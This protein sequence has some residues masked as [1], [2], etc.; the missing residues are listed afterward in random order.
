MSNYVTGALLFEFENASSLELRKVLEWIKSDWT[1]DL[2]IDISNLTNEEFNIPIEIYD[3]LN[4]KD[5][6]TFILDIGFVEMKSNRINIIRDD[7]LN[8]LAAHT[9][10]IRSQSYYENYENNSISTSIRSSSNRLELDKAFEHS[11]SASR[12]G[13]RFRR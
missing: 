3:F 2:N 11:C 4:L 12:F 1:E 7:L 5:K 6:E 10:G 13:A 9:T 8:L